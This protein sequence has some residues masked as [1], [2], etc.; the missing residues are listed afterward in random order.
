MLPC[1]LHM[2]LFN[3]IRPFMPQ[4]DYDGL[5][6]N[7]CSTQLLTSPIAMSA[8]DAYTGFTAEQ[9]NNPAGLGGL[10]SVSVFRDKG[11]PNV[12]AEV[13]ASCRT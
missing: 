1:T 2:P 11:S 10:G 6:N 8:L 12:S 7:C 9:S 13:C 3:Q 5:P 4:Q